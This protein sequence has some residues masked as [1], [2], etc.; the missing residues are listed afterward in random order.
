MHDNFALLQISCH[1]EP[2]SVLLKETLDALRSEAIVHAIHGM[3]SS[4]HTALCTALLMPNR[5][6]PQMTR[7]PP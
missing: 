6:L 7:R 4:R 1:I 2:P 3:G 5:L